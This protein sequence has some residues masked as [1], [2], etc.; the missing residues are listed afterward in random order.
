MSCPCAMPAPSAMQWGPPA[1]QP[2]QQPSISQEALRHQHVVNHLACREAVCPQGVDPHNLAVWGA[3]R[4]NMERVN[5]CREPAQYQN[6]QGDYGA[7]VQRQPQQMQQ[8]PQMQHDCCAHLGGGGYGTSTTQIQAPR[9]VSY[10]DWG[11]RWSGSPEYDA[12]GSPHGFYGPPAVATML[13]QMGNGRNMGPVGGGPGAMNGCGPCGGMGPGMGGMGP[14]GYI[15]NHYG[16]A[17][18]PMQHATANKPDTSHDEYYQKREQEIRTGQI[19]QGPRPQGTKAY[20]PETPTEP[21]RY[22]VRP[23]TTADRPEDI[24]PASGGAPGSPVPGKRPVSQRP[25]SRR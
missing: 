14:Q 8:M 3:R 11:G 10:I 16:N 24:R 5:V 12:K 17:Y 15:P 23:A 21:G 7:V 4:D 13:Q 1:M 18:P 6:P 20:Y 22:T 9:T 19:S 25:P 2:P